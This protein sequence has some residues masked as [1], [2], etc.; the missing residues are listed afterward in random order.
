MDYFLSYLV[1][2]FS[3]IL[4][5]I[6]VSAAITFK[7]KGIKFKDFLRNGTGAIASALLALGS[8]AVIALIIFLLP[9][10]ANASVFDDGTWANDASVFVGLDYTLKPSPQCEISDPVDDRGTSNLGAKF[11]IWRDRTETLSINSVYTHHSCFL[12]E[13]AKSYDGFGIQVEWKLWKR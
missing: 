7:R 12:G 6:V 3:I 5:V 10:N 1:A 2:F 8:I 4:A 13:D 9:G 11:N